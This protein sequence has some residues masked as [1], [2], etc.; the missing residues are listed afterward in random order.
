MQQD[1]E[2]TSKDVSIPNVAG[3]VKSAFQSARAGISNVSGSRS[4]H[5]GRTSWPNIEC[6]RLGCNTT[7]TRS[8]FSLNCPVPAEQH[9]Q[10]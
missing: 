5:L 3:S 2:K 6:S 7:S 1:A 8:N 9:M 10:A 4:W